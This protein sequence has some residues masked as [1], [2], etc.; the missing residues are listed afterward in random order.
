MLNDRLQWRIGEGVFRGSSNLIDKRL[1]FQAHDS[2]FECIENQ[3]TSKPNK[4]LCMDELYS[5]ET[6]CNND[7]IF[8]RRQHFL[9]NQMDKEI[10]TQDRLDLI[11][12][13]RNFV[14]YSK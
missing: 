7:F 6:Y 3:H 11:N 4:Y 5:Y 9:R 2:Y 12:A 13:K 1:C 8:R 10:W 14:Q